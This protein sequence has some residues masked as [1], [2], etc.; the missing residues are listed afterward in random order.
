MG[1]ICD[2]P[3]HCSFTLRLSGQRTDLTC[4]KTISHVDR[5]FPT[6]GFPGFER[7]RKN[8]NE[9]RSLPGRMTLELINPQVSL[10]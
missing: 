7:P 3:A 6:T 4:G 5:K 10:H 1:A 9:G 8:K 2:T